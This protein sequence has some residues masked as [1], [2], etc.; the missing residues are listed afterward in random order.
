MSFNDALYSTSVEAIFHK[1]KIQLA[2]FKHLFLFEKHTTNYYIALDYGEKRIGIAGASFYSIFSIG[3]CHYQT[4]LERFNGLKK[5][6]DEWQPNAII[7]GL[8]MHSD[9]SAH[10]LT[11]VCCNFGLDLCRYFKLPII[12]VDER[13]TSDI[14]NKQY[15]QYIDDKSAMLIAQDF[16]DTCQQYK[17][18]T[19]TPPCA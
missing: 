6:I 7:L 8:P 3:I 9:A 18:Y 4:R 13:H 10:H 5:H 17:F 15:Q 16:I 19:H 2:Y 11:Q 12:W 14:F 1:H